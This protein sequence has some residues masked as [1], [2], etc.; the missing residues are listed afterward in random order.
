MSVSFYYRITNGEGETIPAWND[1]LNVANMS[2]TII[3][4]ATD[5]PDP[6]PYVGTISIADAERAARNLLRGEARFYSRYPHLADLREF[7]GEA[8][9]NRYAVSL[10]KLV[11]QAK[12]AGATEIVYA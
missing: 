11:E 6:E 5:V 7:Y 1:D 8:R 12:E 9:L 2:A 4:A 10:S 3:L